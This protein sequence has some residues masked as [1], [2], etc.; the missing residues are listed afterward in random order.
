MNISNINCNDY[1]GEFNLSKAKDEVFA[2]GMGC[3][4]LLIGKLRTL[5][6]N[7]KTIKRKDFVGNIDCR[8]CGQQYENEIWIGLYFNNILFSSAY[9]L[10]IAI[11]DA[12]GSISQKLSNTSINFESHYFAS[13]ET[14]GRWIFI[15]LDNY[16]LNNSSAF[17]TEINKILKE[18]I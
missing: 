4:K 1:Q 6:G 18:I 5:T 7:V 11:K 16:L 15:K 13:E 17:V 12:N 2:D 9:Q 14:K 3:S 10:T 8:Y